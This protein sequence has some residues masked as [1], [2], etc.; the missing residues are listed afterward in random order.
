[1]PPLLA[2]QL[3]AASA[4]VTDAGDSS[5]LQSAAVQ[6]L[7]A[8]LDVQLLDAEVKDVDLGRLDAWAR[9]AILDATAED[10]AALLGDAATLETIAAR[11]NVDSEASAA[12]EALRAAADI[13]D[14]A[15]AAEAAMLLLQA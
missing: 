7:Q 1:M 3:S 11:S 14:F 12:I 9:Q 5:E 13:G 6:A 10:G 2:D 4:A 15:A 8:A